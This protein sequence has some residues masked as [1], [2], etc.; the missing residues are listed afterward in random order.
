MGAFSVFAVFEDL[1]NYED[2][3]ISV[4]YGPNVNQRKANFWSELDS[5]R[6]RWKGPWCIGGDFNIIRFPEVKLGGCWI[7][8]EMTTFFRLDKQ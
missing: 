4:V 5:I 2:C 7:S 8:P 1:E 3:I 6:L